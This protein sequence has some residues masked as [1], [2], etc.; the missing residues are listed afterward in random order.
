[1]PKLDLKTL[2]YPTE[3]VM[4]NDKENCFVV[5]DNT[6]TPTKKPAA[7]DRLANSPKTL[8][9]STPDKLKAR[10]EAAQKKK[11]E[12][13]EKRKLKAK[14][15]LELAKTR[16]QDPNL[17]DRRSHTNYDEEVVLIADAEPSLVVVID[18]TRTPTKKPVACERLANSPKTL[19]PSTPDK[20]KARE[21][22][23]QKKKEETTEK[24]KLKAKAELELAKT[25]SQDPNLS[26][27]RSQ[28]DYEKEIVL[29]PTAETSLVVVIDNTRTPTK[30]PVACERLA[31]SPKTLFPST[32]DKLKAREEAAQ[33]KKEENTEKRKLKAKTELE[34]A[35]TRS[36]DPNLSDRRSQTDYEK[37]IV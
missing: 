27:R 11:E 5:L 22:A 28:T 36:Q 23:A 25:R 10:E 21:E 2:I 34:L 20:L 18:N 12:T 33:K 1:L 29:M 7:C 30:K 14:T 16:S 15:E 17:S 13:T 19:F 24:R 9:P 35:K 26:D 37:E 31:N 6:R 8:F 3:E 32:P 4:S